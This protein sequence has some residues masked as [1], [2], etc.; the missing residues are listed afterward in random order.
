MWY[1]RL[2][3]RAAAVPA[4]VLIHHPRFNQFARPSI[5]LCGIYYNLSRNPDTRSHRGPRLN[6]AQVLN[7]DDGLGPLESINCIHI[8]L[9]IHFPV[10]LL[11][12]SL[13]SELEKFCPITLS[14]CKA[15]DHNYELYPRPTHLHADFLTIMMFSFIDIQVILSFQKRKLC[16]PKIQGL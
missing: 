2:M 11:S 4:G 1:R 12:K 3:D 16:S 8:F 9:F 15:L 14:K 10:P 5:K 6:A 13:L 7:V